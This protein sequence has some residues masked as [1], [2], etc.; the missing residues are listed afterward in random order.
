[1]IP[2]NQGPVQLGSYK[3][4]SGCFACHLKLPD[5]KL[6]MLYRFATKLS[7]VN[8]K[9]THLCLERGQIGKGVIP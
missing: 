8:K 3:M 2:V 4:I 5:N 9:S 6:N 1:M 7:K